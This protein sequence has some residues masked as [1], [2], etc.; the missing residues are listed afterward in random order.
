MSIDKK[1]EQ[2]IEFLDALYRADFNKIEKLVDSGICSF[3]RVTPVE[4]WNWLHISLMD[5]NK[6]M[7][8]RESI[9]YLIDKGVDVNAQDCYCMTPLHYAMR[10]KN[11]GAAMALLEVGANPNAANLK[12]IIPLAY[13]NGQPEELDL[14]KLMLDKGGDVHF[15]N[16]YETILEGVTEHSLTN[17]KLVPVLKTMQEHAENSK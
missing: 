10:K 15:Y 6:E 13:I 5:F 1:T 11:V 16:G 8:P 3:S 4:N 12:N 17:D 2:A 9:E 14:L 7:P